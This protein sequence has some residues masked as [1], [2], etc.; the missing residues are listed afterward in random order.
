MTNI[1]IKT[2]GMHCKSC[3]MLVEDAL[4]DLEGVNKV[5]ANSESG[6]INIEC[7]SGKVSKDKVNE[8]IE[9]EHADIQSNIYRL[10]L[11]LFCGH[12]L[13]PDGHRLLEDADAA[14]GN[15]NAVPVL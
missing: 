6:I 14:S 10:G 3:E 5:K 1:E 8:I 12:D 11:Q 15:D 2:K 4:S 13:S 7:E 9:K